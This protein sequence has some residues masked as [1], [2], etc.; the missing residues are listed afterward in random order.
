MYGWMDGWMIMR[1][2]FFAGRSHNYKSLEGVLSL[3]SC[4]DGN[5]NGNGNGTSEHLPTSDYD[6]ELGIC[7]RC[8]A[9]CC[10]AME[11]K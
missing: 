11:N 6:H 8:D 7:V 10:Y 1:E 2:A 5:G 9:M 4:M 3:E